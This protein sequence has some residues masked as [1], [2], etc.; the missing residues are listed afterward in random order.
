SNAAVQTLAQLLPAAAFQLRGA[1]LFNGV[2]GVPRGST[3]ATYRQFQ[4]RIGFAY[5]LT[6]NTVIRGG[7]GRFVQGTAINPGQNGFSRS[8]SLLATKDNYMTYY[9]TLDNPYRD[10]I[11]APTGSSLGP[12]TN[13]GQGPSWTNPDAG[14]P[15]A[16]IYSLHVQRQLKGWLLEVGYSHNKTADT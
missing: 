1:Q 3:D 2:N 7:V 14:R 6:P 5:R 16:W 12:L 11:L 8:T 9:D 15:Y 10:G 4:P 13:L